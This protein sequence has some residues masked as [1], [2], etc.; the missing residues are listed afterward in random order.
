MNEHKPQT[1]L[2][3]YN[4]SWYSTGANVLVRL[5][6]FAVNALF[7]K[8]ALNGS[9]KLKVLL[10]RLFGAKIG[11]GVMIKP[12]VNI[13]YPW[14]LQVDDHTWIGEEVWIDNL[15]QVTIGAHCC[16]SQGA[17]ILS[18]NHNFK[19]TSFDLMVAPITLEDGV[20]IGAKAVVTYSSYCESHAV[21]AVGSVASGRLKA[22]TI[23]RG[24]PAEAI[25]ERDLT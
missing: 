1:D 23:Y 4:N 19:K 5:L 8:N 24:N 6:W 3:N 20:W 2:A 7:F 11:R 10:L 16:L 9:S 15:D 17:M 13:K 22:Y 14:K 21:L 12:A 25:R 18:G